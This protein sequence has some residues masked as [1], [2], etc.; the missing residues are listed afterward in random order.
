MD[1]HN[2][3]LQYLRHKELIKHNY[4]PKHI[5]L[6]VDFSSLQKRE[7]LYLG[8]QFL[9]YMLWNADI[10]KFT[11]SYEGFN[12]L[13]YHIPL[14][15]YFGKTHALEEAFKNKSNHTPYRING[16]RGVEKKWNNELDRAKSK[17]KSY[18]IT[19]EPST[20]DLFEDFLIECAENN[21]KVTM[22]YTPEYIEGQDFIKNRVDIIDTYK[23]YAENYNIDFLDYSKDSICL[24]KKYFYNSMHLNKEGSNLF[25]KTLS[26]DLKRLKL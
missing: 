13:D 15:R 17:M 26:K 2:F 24:N 25:T 9:P 12:I 3:W 11:T 19:I 21:S 7:N 14:I 22:I 18:E 6:A 23:K 1:G 16:Y 5:L 20:L 10:K 4:F 8:E